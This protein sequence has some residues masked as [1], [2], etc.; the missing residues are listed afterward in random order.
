[1]SIGIV[2]KHLKYK[3]MPFLVKKTYRFCYVRKWKDFNKRRL[4]YLKCVFCLATYVVGE[5]TYGHLMGFSVVSKT[6]RVCARELR[7]K[8]QQK[9]DTL[10]QDVPIKTAA[11]NEAAQ[12]KLASWRVTT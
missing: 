1:M 11:S 10:T 3:E 8:L 4:T 7:R 12:A 5:P 9:G 6:H 2:G